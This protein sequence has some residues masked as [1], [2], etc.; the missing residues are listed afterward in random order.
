M[1]KNGERLT[2]INQLN[3]RKKYYQENKNNPKTKEAIK[4][5]R[6][7]HRD[8]INKNSAN[9]KEVNYQKHLLSSAKYRAKRKGLEFNLELSDIIIPDKCPYLETVLTSEKLK[10]H[11]D[12]HMSVD[13]IDNSKGYIKGNIEII[14]YKANVMKHNA[15]KEQL[16]TFA[17]NVLRKF[18]DE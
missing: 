6:Q 15:S 13:R 11:R 17:L 18:K 7:K 2:K 3:I 14:S 10:G 12:S 1:K 5:Y 9:W 8:R 16:I 4:L